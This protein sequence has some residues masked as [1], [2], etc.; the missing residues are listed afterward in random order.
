MAESAEKFPKVFWTANV[1]E[2]FERAAYYSMASFV[3]IYLGQLGLG[4]VLAEHA[5]RPALVPRLLPAHPLGHHRRPGRLPPLA[6][7]RVRAAGRRLLPDGL[8][9]LVRRRDA[10]PTVGDEVTAGAAVVVPV[11]VGI[12]L[13]GMGGSVVKPCISGTVQKTA[14][15]RATLGLRHLLHGHQHRLARRPRRRLLRA[16]ALA[17]LSV[18]FAVAHRRCACVAFFVVLLLYRDPEPCRRQRA[19]QAASKSIGQILARHGAGA[20]ATAASPSSCWS[21][22]ASGSS[23]TRS[24]TCCRST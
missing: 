23:T 6:A 2:L 18:I 12:L 19:G 7:G 1:T 10:R 20:R 15:G 13:I 22:A 5:Q 3:V 16:H 9:G 8:P 21:R 17:S 14:G 24:T 4:D 11:V